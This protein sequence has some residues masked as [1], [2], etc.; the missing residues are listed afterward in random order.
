MTFKIMIDCIK[1]ELRVFH[2]ALHGLCGWTDQWGSKRMNEVGR[3]CDRSLARRVWY[4]MLMKAY[5]RSRATSR[6]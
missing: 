4:Q 6:D 3:S 5:D 2:L 1:E